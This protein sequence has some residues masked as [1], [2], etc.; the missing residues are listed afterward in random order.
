MQKVFIVV[1]N[2][3]GCEDTIECIESLKR[4]DYQDYK[5]LVI[6]NGSTDES[7]DIIPKKYLQEIIFIATKKNLGFAGGNNVGIKY[8]FENP[9]AG[10]GADYILLLNNDT[11][12]ESDF[13]SKLVEVAESD[14]NIGVVGP[15]INFY[16]HTLNTENKDQLV[17]SD[18]GVGVYDKR[19]TIWFGGGKVNWLKTKGTHIDY[20]LRQTTTDYGLRTMA[21]GSRSAVVGGRPTDYITG[22]CLLIKR[23]VIEKIGFLSEDYFLYYEDVDWCLSA[24]KAGFKSVFV[25]SARIYHKHSRS[26]KESSYPYIYYHSRNGLILSSRGGFKIF[27]Y[28]IS[29][30]IYL[31]QILK[32]IIGYKKEWARPVMH[33]VKDFWGGKRGKLEG[34][35]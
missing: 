5:I 27:A 15:Q 30:W 18:K 4:I 14:R 31:K 33:G 16:P 11:I 2:W 35:Y 10:G 9:P 21:G 3:N 26:T 25:P 22:C 13:L 1:L 20:G 29:A 32:L 8:A 19:D 12:V 17:H 6:D 7:L 23:E 28:L 34:Y 24:K